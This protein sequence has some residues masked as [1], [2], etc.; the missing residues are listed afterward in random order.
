SSLPCFIYSTHHTFESTTKN[1]SL[2]RER[3]GKVYFSPA[4]DL[5]STK[6]AMPEDDEQAALTI[7]GK[8]NKLK[9]SDFI[10]LAK[11]LQ[12]NEKSVEM[13]LSNLFKKEEELLQTVGASFLSTEQKTTYIEL[14]KNRLAV[15]M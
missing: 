12:L 13:V 2:V 8:K 7:N 5:V 3:D 1:F 10:N 14:I 9:K 15:L 4:Y 6:L 11:T